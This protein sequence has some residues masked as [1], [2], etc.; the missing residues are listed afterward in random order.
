MPPLRTIWSCW[1]PPKFEELSY[2]FYPGEAERIFRTPDVKFLYFA[3]GLDSKSK[4]KVTG[5]KIPAHLDGIWFIRKEV[6]LTDSC[7]STSSYVPLTGTVR[8]SFM[9][10]L[11]K[12]V[13]AILWCS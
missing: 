1:D 11:C 10:L 13:S 2:N 12:C 8:S 7:M 5:F 4:K 6:V 9:Y 3:F